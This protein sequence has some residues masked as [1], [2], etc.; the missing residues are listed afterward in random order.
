MLRPKATN[1]TWNPPSI[2]LTAL[3]WTAYLPCCPWSIGN[4]PGDELLEPSGEKRGLFIKGAHYFPTAMSRIWNTLIPDLY[5]NTA[6][7]EQLTPFKGCL[8]TLCEWFFPIFTHASLCLWISALPSIRTRTGTHTRLI[9][10]LVGICDQ[11]SEVFPWFRSLLLFPHDTLKLSTGEHK[12]IQVGRSSLK[13]TDLYGWHL[14]VCSNFDISW[15]VFV[16]GEFFFF[17]LWVPEVTSSIL[18]L[19]YTALVLAILNDQM[20]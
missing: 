5:A 19:Y 8:E 2:R 6:I 16:T 10:L 14:K 1:Q 4:S 3:S 11:S 7:L 18:V 12:S 15:W 17:F 9:C 20:M 13:V